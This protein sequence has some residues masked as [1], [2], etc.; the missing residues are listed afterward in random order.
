MNVTNT[1]NLTNIFEVGE[2]LFMESDKNFSFEVVSSYNVKPLFGDEGRKV[3]LS[4]GVKE[5]IMVREDYTPNNFNPAEEVVNNEN[6]NI[7]ELARLKGI[8]V[9]NPKVQIRKEG[10]KVGLFEKT[11]YSHF[12][13]S[14][15]VVRSDIPEAAGYNPNDSELWNS[16][17][18]GGDGALT[19][20]SLTT[21][22]FNKGWVSDCCNSYPKKVAGLVL[23]SQCK[24]EFV[25]SVLEETS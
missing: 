18:D 22:L 16:Y 13:T 5:A 17:L 1:I 3:R 19:N 14:D 24:G 8:K 12:L 10:I 25:S 7:V 15:E 11:V 21:E 6:I 23:C 20:K 4:V 2:I 9:G